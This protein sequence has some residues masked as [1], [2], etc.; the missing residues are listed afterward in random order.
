MGSAEQI[1]HEAG[2]GKLEKRQVNFPI[3]NPA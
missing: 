1:E 3:R 2:G